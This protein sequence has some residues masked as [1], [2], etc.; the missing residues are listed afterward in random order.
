MKIIKMNRISALIFT[1]FLTGLLNAQ[2]LPQITQYMCNNYVINPAVSGMYDYYQVNT[3]IRN[4]WAGIT[5]GP[6]TSLISIYGKKSNRIALGG[7]VYNDVTGPTSRIGASTSY[8]YVLPLTK[9]IQLALAL[10]AGFTQFKVIKE[11]LSAADQ[12]DV[13]LEGG[14]VVRALPDATFGFNLSGN[15]WYLGAAIPQLLSSELKLMDE[16]FAQLYDTTS[17]DGKLARHVYVL[18]SYNYSVNT[19]ISIQPSFFLKSVQGAKTQIDFGIKSEYRDM[20]WIGMNYK[21]NNNL[22]SIATLLGYSINDRFNIGYSYGIPS[23]NT[24]N[25]Y[26]GSHE[27]MLGIKFPS[28]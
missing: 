9:K 10:Q 5:D 24:S 17:Q 1:V 28:K 18:G 8:T 23:S 3:T 20:F 22:S 14:D 16:D 7:M 11:G 26:S 2:Q 19:L 25:Y 12:G 27:V 6:R 15:Q 4:Q 21:M 13:L